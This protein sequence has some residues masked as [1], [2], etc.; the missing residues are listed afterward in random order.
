MLS[1]PSSLMRVPAESSSRFWNKP[2]VSNVT[3]EYFALKKNIFSDAFIIKT[4]RLHTTLVLHRSPPKDLNQENGSS[5]HFYWFKSPTWSRK[6]L[7][8]S[9]STKHGGKSTAS[10]R[11]CLF[12][13]ALSFC[14]QQK[15]VV[16]ISLIQLRKQTVRKNASKSSQN[17]QKWHLS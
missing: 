1:L 2:N 3:S 6:G 13:R 12:L 17:S 8:A 9:S 4:I 16:F 10:L 5:A 15:L 14:N 7:E 11:R